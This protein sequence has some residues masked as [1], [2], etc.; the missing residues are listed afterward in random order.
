MALLPP[1]LLGERQGSREEC[2]RVTRVAGP[3]Q[4]CTLA[5]SLAEQ[6]FLPTRILALSAIQPCLLSR[7]FTDDTPNLEKSCVDL[8][9]HTVKLRL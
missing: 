3:N 4:G 8:F 5:F 1:L 6:A 9:S 7:N 2:C